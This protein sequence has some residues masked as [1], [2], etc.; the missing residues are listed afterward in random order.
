MRRIQLG[1]EDAAIFETFVVPRYLSLFGERVTAMLAEGSDARVCHL[2][3]RT[4]YPDRT[5]LER[6]PGAHVYG[7]DP[8]DHAVQLARTKA[9]ALAHDRAGAIFDYW[10]APSLPLPFPGGAFSHGFVLH[11]FASSRQSFLEELARIL[12]PSGQAIVAMPIRGSFVEILDLLRE[13]ALKHELTE[14]ARALDDA[15]ALRPT[16][17]MF[18]RELERVGFEFVEID[19]R[20]R[21]L[22]LPSGRAFLEDPVIRLLVIPELRATLG[23]GEPRADE[24]STEVLALDPFDYVRDAIDKYWSDGSF[25][26]TV[27]VGVVSGRRRG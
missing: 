5:L 27:N 12:A 24:P 7:C 26:V 1:H 2:D 14:L 3:C 4:G 15:S 16:D 20:Q 19:V 22:K 11:P 8:S 10:V 17:D 18:M 25:A 21:S 9:A 23:L 6:L 13:C